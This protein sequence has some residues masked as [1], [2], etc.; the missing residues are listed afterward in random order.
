MRGRR[1]SLPPPPFLPPLLGSS[2]SKPRPR[3]PPHP[4]RDHPHKHLR[5]AV[6]RIAR[7]PRRAVGE[8][9]APKP[10]PRILLPAIRCTDPTPCAWLRNSGP[11]QERSKE[12]PGRL[13]CVLT[14]SGVWLFP[15]PSCWSHAV[16]T[17]LLPA[18]VFT[19]YCACTFRQSPLR[20]QQP[21]RRPPRSS[22]R[23]TSRSDN[24]R[25][26]PLPSLLPPPAPRHDAPA[27]LLPPLAPARSDRSEERDGRVITCGPSATAVMVSHAV[28]PPPRG[29][30]SVT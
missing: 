4:T 7:P 9:R 15:L 26:L 24:P 13:P 29:A 3:L 6:R 12:H 28:L 23:Q 25:E 21:R 5:L 18:S 10:T 11:E 19:P 30:P 20:R 16:T 2:R 1:W 17:P 22:G 8:R 27:R 14:E